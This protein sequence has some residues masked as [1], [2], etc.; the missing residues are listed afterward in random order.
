MPQRRAPEA[1]P[2][3]VTASL[4]VTLPRGGGTAAWRRG[5]QKPWLVE[6]TQRQFLNLSITALSIICNDIRLQV[7]QRDAHLGGVGDS[8]NSSHTIPSDTDRP[9]RAVSRAASLGAPI[10]STYRI[11]TRLMV[12]AKAVQY[13]LP[14]Y[15]RTHAS[16]CIVLTVQLYSL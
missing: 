4:D 15:P 1:C 3:G 7:Y 13:L 6:I 9:E 16:Y 11:S 5:V 2:R 12:K 10:G 14:K 8:N